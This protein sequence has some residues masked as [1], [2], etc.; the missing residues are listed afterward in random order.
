LKVGQGKGMHGKNQ[1]VGVGV[2]W[3][4]G[5]SEVIG[6]E[7]EN[8]NGLPWREGPEWR[9]GGTANVFS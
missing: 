5:K 8:R 1:A 4:A 9:D 6:Q 3:H 7:T 2:Q